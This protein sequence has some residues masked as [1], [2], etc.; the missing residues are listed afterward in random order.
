M[1][2]TIE[3]PTAL[4]T[5]KSG[6]ITLSPLTSSDTEQLF[7]LVV[8]NRM[9]LRT[10]L[11]WVDETNAVDHTEKF[12]QDA[13][14]QHQEQTG[15]YY[16]MWLDN[17]MIGS[18]SF[19]WIDKRNKK[20]IMGYWMDEAHQGKG[21][22]TTAATLLTDYGFKTLGLHR[23]EIA[24]AKDNNTSS[25]IPLKLGFQKEAVLREAEWLN[26]HFTDLELYSIL[27]RDWENR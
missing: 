19:H 17:E 1:L 18:I 20:A 26:D 24:V 9:H 13:L 23:L 25:A 22:T 21:L 2:K 14:R 5:L 16:L 10:W 4:P 11:N 12:V 8:K 7:H 3:F 6:G 27:V 15:L